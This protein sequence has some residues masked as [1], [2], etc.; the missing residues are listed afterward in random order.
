MD[1]LTE[2]LTK[3]K[4]EP[5]FDDLHHDYESSSSAQANIR[6]NL[7]KWKIAK[8]GGKPIA[9][10]VGKS[11]ARP[12]LIRK[13]YEYKYSTYEEPFLNTKDMFKISGRT[14]EDIEAAKQN[15]M[16]LNYQWSTKLKKVKLVGDIIKT[17]VDDGSVIVKTGWESEEG[18]K[19]VEEERPTYA[20][21]DESLSIMQQRVEAGEMTE[22][23]AYAMMETGELIQTGIEKVYVEK[24][25]LIKNQPTYEVCQ[26]ENTIIDPTCEGDID[27]ANFIIHEYSTS[28]AELATQEFQQWTEEEVQKDGSI[29]EIKHESGIYRNLN[30]LKVEDGDGNSSDGEYIYNE[31]DDDN[32]STMRFKDKA[33]KKLRAFEYW[34]FYPI[35]GDD[36]LVPI[37]ATWIGKTIVRLE[38]NPFPH[39]KLPFS[40][41][42][43]MSVNREVMGEPD[44]EVLSENQDSVGRMTRAAEDIVAATAVGQVMMDERFLPDA[45]QKNN[46]KLGKTVYFRGDLDPKKA[47]HVSKP[48]EVPGAIFNLVDRNKAESDDMAGSTN[49]GSAAAALGAPAVSIRSSLDSR[50]K[51]EL[52]ILR[53]LSELFVDMARMTIAMNQAYLDDE[54]VVR[55]TNEE[56]V[57]VR[58]DDLGGDFDLSIDIST[59]EKDEEAATKLTTLLQTNAASMD[60]EEARLIRSKLAALWKIPDLE[61]QIENFKPTPPEPT[62]LDM[63]NLQNAKLIN[64]K[65]KK[66]L[67]ESDSRIHERISR[68]LENEK[69]VDNKL[70]Q[71]ELRIQQ[72]L[73]S[74][75][76]TDKLRAETEI[77]GAEF[78]S[79]VSGEKRKE[80]LE[81]KQIDSDI[82]FAEMES[83]SEVENLKIQISEL[84]NKLKQTTQG[85]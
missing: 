27:N 71:M 26:N 50:A 13:N 19:I 16:I 17:Y 73:E 7:H 38:E 2:K 41:A 30:L 12:L 53:K 62:E 32:A 37:V 20:S 84:Q 67:E 29:K 81:N 40:I 21:V 28:Y 59:P 10:E 5:K 51:R 6:Q 68:V 57:T 85:V 56:F 83:K 43:Y 1:R 82:K 11:T 47:I 63:L 15:A 58:R 42:T 4:N 14:D 60:P 77:V 22:A 54:E 78:V 23:Q 69:D 31:F 45:V 72:K 33:R 64:E 25:T 8:E 49:G 70:A 44:A 3:W 48:P 35:H 24:E 34:G 52:S 80:E 74:M 76:R 65:L 18:T 55:L 39:K 9:A 46:Y 61:K 66:D 79:R 75:A 36:I